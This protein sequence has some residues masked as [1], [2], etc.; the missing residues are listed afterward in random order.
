MDIRDPQQADSPPETERVDRWLRHRLDPTRAQVERV[1]RG[2]LAAERRPAAPARRGWAVA[3]AVAAVLA[4]VAAGLAW[5]GGELA[6]SPGGG[7]GVA[8][9]LATVTITNVAGEVEL[10][11]HPTPL[12][13]PPECR[14]AVFNS[15]GLVA[16]EVTG[17][18]VRYMLVGGDT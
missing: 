14:A 9:E 15:D 10:R 13:R 5:L 8:P 4:L 7:T 12:A 16:A 11:L 18:G 3:A 1:V 17:D 6:P 2:A